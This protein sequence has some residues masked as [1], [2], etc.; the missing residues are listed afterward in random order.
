M[1]NTYVLNEKLRI[2]FSPTFFINENLL[3]FKVI[4]EKEK[5]LLSL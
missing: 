2:F 5:S 1:G 3:N 4:L